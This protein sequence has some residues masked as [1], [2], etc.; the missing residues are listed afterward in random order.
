MPIPIPGTALTCP[1]CPV[2]RTSAAAARRRGRRSPG[3]A[4][5]RGRTWHAPAPCGTS[6]ARSA[7]ARMGPAPP[8]PYSPVGSDVQPAGG[9]AGARRLPQSPEAQQRAEEALHGRTGA[10]HGRAP[11][12][13][14][15][16]GSLT[17]TRSRIP[18]ASSSALRAAPPLAPP[19][20]ACSQWQ[21]SP[22]QAPPPPLQPMGAG[23]S[24]RTLWRKRCG[25]CGRIRGGAGCRRERRCFGGFWRAAAA[26]ARLWGSDYGNYHRNCS[27]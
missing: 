17:G 23:S 2:R 24:R 15:S 16:P 6:T 9:R 25:R 18:P 3:S 13:G 27:Q 22:P 14:P 21:T 4:R 19:H 8:A 7:P 20:R 10:S 12:P 26:S 1:R 5:R 11:H